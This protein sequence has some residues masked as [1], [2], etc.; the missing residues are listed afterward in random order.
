MIAEPRP[1]RMSWAP[2]VL[3]LAITAVVLVASYALKAQCVDQPWDGRQWSHFCATDILVVYYNEGFDAG[4][5]RF[6]PATVEYPPLIGFY[7]GAAAALSSGAA[8][9][10]LANAAGI[11][12]AAIAAVLLLTKMSPSRR[13]YLFV[14]SP[15]LFLYAFQNWDLLVVALGLA[16]LLAATRRRYGMSGVLLGV[17]AAVKFFPALLLPGVYLA[18][19]AKGGGK[20]GWRAIGG[21]LA[22]VLP[23]N[24]LLFL[25]SR[26]AWEYFW[27]FQSARFPNPETSW[28]MVF[29]H[30]RGGPF[31]DGWWARN[32]PG[33]INVASA[34]ALLAIGIWIVAKELR[35]PEPRMVSTGLCLTIAFLLTS[36]VFSPQYMLWLLPLLIVLEVPV[37]ALIGFFVVDVWCFAMANAYF[38]SI[39]RGWDWAIRLDILEAGV[40]ARYAVLAWLLWWQLH[41]K[42]F[43]SPSLG[44]G[45]PN[46]ASDEGVAPARRPHWM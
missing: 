1:E 35:R 34:F 12:A 9:F 19:R 26:H 10:M 2:T 17:G 6:P 33:I 27:S 39:A 32:Y 36:K 23:A 21:F 25:L 44:S 20:A 38:L 11:A 13:V 4:P 42:E 45:L 16:G 43:P 46:R 22:G 5:A 37:A 31:V 30:L 7:V 41:P 24:I 15:T 28:F 18:A 14:L 29:R 40:W 8:G 3:L